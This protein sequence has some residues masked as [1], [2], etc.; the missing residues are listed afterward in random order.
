MCVLEQQSSVS[1]QK[2]EPINVWSTVEPLTDRGIYDLQF[3][4]VDVL[5]F[6]VR[7]MN[8]LWDLEAFEPLD[9]IGYFFPRVFVLRAEIRIIEIGSKTFCDS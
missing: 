8:V 2:K 5:S 9:S 4:A 1:I 6:G 7:A 3:A